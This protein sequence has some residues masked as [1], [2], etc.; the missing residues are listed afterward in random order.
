MA[1]DV[2]G[3]LGE[4]ASS[5]NASSTTMNRTE[6]ATRRMGVSRHAGCV[7]LLQPVADEKLRSP[8]KSPDLRL[9]KPHD[10]LNVRSF[11]RSSFGTDSRCPPALR[12]AVKPPTITNVLKPFSCSRCATRALVA[13]RAQVQ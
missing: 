5:Q 4:A 9:A 3:W 10:N 7:L 8:A 1:A 11:T 13:S 12:H 2:S 6:E